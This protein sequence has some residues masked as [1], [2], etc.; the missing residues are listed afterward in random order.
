MKREIKEKNSLIM[1]R[2]II[3]VDIHFYMNQIFVDDNKTKLEE[4]LF[5]LK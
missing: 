2:E 5:E 4:C 1:N 3:F